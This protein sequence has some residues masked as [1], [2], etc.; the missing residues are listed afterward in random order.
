MLATVGV[1]SPFPADSTHTASTQSQA[2][3]AGTRGRQAAITTAPAAATF[4]SPHRLA[5]SVT[6]PACTAAIDSPAA[7]IAR[8]IAAGPQP[9]RSRPTTASVVSLPTHAATRR[10]P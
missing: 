4:A 3:P 1:T 5:S 10:Q 7:A 2:G 6:G 8:P 9:Y